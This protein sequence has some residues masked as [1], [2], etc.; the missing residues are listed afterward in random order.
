MANNK[1]Q[2][3]P[4][5]RKALIALSV[6]L[7]LLG[8]AGFLLAF[9]GRFLQEWHIGNITEET[10]ALLNRIGIALMF[11][12]FILGGILLLFVYAFVAKVAVKYSLKA[13]EA[14]GK[15]IDKMET[16]SREKAAKEE[17]EARSSHRPTRSMVSNALHYCNFDHFFD[18][19]TMRFERF[20]IDVTGHRVKVTIHYKSKMEKTNAGYYLSTE[21]AYDLIIPAAKEDA[22]IASN[23]ICNYLDENDCSYTL[24]V[25]YVGR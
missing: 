7:L 1:I 17:R 22:D 25:C 5:A 3:R 18:G 20:E 8:I 21:E 6:F 19:V 4:G 14:I 10:V 9:G 23:A 15:E 2:M 13:F 16:K 12:G 24:R 11:P